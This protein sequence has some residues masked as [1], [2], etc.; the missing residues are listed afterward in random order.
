M[1]EDEVAVAHSSA[2][3]PTPCQA[4]VAMAT[5]VAQ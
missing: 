4:M 5:K 2:H 3:V 1:D